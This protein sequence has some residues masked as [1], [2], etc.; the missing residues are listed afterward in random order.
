[1]MSSM[2]AHDKLL[3]PVDNVKHESIGK[4]LYLMD[5]FEHEITLL[6]AHVGL[7]ATACQAVPGIRLSRAPLPGAAR[8]ATATDVTPGRP[9]KDGLP[10][11]AATA[12]CTASAAAAATAA[13]SRAIP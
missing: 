13:A 11:Y 6:Q 1:M 4:M 2:K 5:G 10:G 7:A 8:N 12:G 3:K 9:A